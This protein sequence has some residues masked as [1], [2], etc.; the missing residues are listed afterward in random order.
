M[1][2]GIF[3]VHEEMADHKAALEELLAGFKDEVVEAWE[4]QD[5]NGE[6]LATDLSLGNVRSKTRI[7]PVLFPPNEH[8]VTPFPDV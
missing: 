4:Q 5:E 7:L 2:N 1:K 6:A 8:V 3:K